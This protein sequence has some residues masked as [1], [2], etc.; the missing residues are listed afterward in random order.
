[1]ISQLLSRELS[2]YPRPSV[3]ITESRS[4]LSLDGLKSSHVASEAWRFPVDSQRCPRQSPGR[5]ALRVNPGA[6]QSPRRASQS[7]LYDDLVPFRVD[8]GPPGRTGRERMVADSRSKSRNVRDNRAELRMV[9]GHVISPKDRGF[10]PGSGPV[11]THRFPAVY[12][13]CYHIDRYFVP[14]FGEGVSVVVLDVTFRVD[15]GCPGRATSRVKPG[16]SQSVLR[17][18]LVSLLVEPRC[19]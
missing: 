14:T 19:E 7:T 16:G 4:L 2:R 1:M 9:L 3:A 11:G 8:P 12:G 13:S 17:D 18:A 10:H 5:A 15:P 6:S